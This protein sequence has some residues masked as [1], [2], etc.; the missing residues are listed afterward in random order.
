MVGVRLVCIMVMMGLVAAAFGVPAAAAQESPLDLY[1]TL[2]YEVIITDSADH[3]DFTDMRE[4]AIG[5]PGDETIVVRIKVGAWSVADAN[6]GVHLFY[7]AGGKNFRSGVNGAGRPASTN[8]WS[9]CY[10][11]GATAYCTMPYETLGVAVGDQITATYGI[12]YI[13]VAQ[14]YA[15][16]LLF[17]PDGVLAP[18][19]KDYTITGGPARPAELPP[20]NITVELPS[21][22]V[23]ENGSVA[24]PFHVANHA[25]DNDTVA[26]TIDSAPANWTVEVRDSSGTAVANA[27]L[28]PGSNASFE[29]AVANAL[30]PGVQNV[31]LNVTSS[32]GFAQLFSVSVLVPM[33]ESPANESAP[34]TQNATEAAAT[35]EAAPV[36]APPILLAGLAIAGVA[37]ALRRRIK[38]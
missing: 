13:A 10:R 12:S 14:D 30:E 19:G 27:T 26:F 33:P 35:D 11:D 36:P 15:P 24:L 22:A 7:T 2:A 1:K 16:G 8:P 17:V 37:L 18:H 28:G 32:M 3:A 9:E 29:L 21:E 34:G 23:A 31:T 20:A 4:F 5:E 25:V 38:Y 6:L